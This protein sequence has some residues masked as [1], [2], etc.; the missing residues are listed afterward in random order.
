MQRS[1]DM[2]QSIRQSENYVS[3]KLPLTI[4]HPTD[5]T[6]D[7]ENDYYI[8]EIKVTEV[9]SFVPITIQKENNR[10]EIEFEI[11]YG[12][13]YGQNETKAIAM[14]ILDQSLEFGSKGYPTQDEEFV[15]FILIRSSRVGLSPI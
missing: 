11:G 3:E 15:C 9:E 5:L 6:D 14:S 10:E 7:K 2:V 4:G 1:V 13:C 12:I 8:G